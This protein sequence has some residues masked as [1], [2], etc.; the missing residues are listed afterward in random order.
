MILSSEKQWNAN[1]SD[2]S[3]IVRWPVVCP[4]SIAPQSLAGF[5][6]CQRWFRAILVYKY[7]N[8]N[9]HLTTFVSPSTVNIL[10]K[11]NLTLN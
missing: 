3:K 2:D 5:V 6:L 11:L 9:F 10:Q 7:Y 4:V 8:V 1:L